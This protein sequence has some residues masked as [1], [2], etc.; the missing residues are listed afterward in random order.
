MS[1]M[2][3]SGCGGG[4]DSNSDKIAPTITLKG[5]PVV[6]V[7]HGSTYT[8]QGATALDDNDGTVSVST[9]GRVDTSILGSYTL[10]YTAND[11]AGNIAKAVRTVNVVD[12][13]TFGLVGYYEF[14]GNTNDSSALKNNG[15]NSNA[16][17]IEGVVG[18]N[19]ISIPDCLTQGKVTLE[20]LPYPEKEFT[21]AYFIRLD[22]NYTWALNN[23][24]CFLND[25]N[26]GYRTVFARLNK[27]LYGIQQTIVQDN[28]KFSLSFTSHYQNDNSKIVKSTA[29]L[30]NFKLGTWV[31]LAMV[32]TKKPEVITYMNGVEISRT[33]E[34]HAFLDVSAGAPEIGGHVD[35]MVYK[36]NSSLGGSLD[37]FRL[38]NRALSAAEIKGFY[39][40]KSN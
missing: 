8:D 27:Y 16:Y 15:V 29:N 37:D 7:N 3:L 28:N 36:S 26:T 18:N 25:G 11:K 2:S 32:F 12:L 6:N 22:S 39:N 35:T 21:I 23:S 19:A 9:M 5:E 31:H 38:Y 4:D 1:L 30:E 34:A 24:G 20:S 17:Y 13:K 10:T 14:E 40:S 33:A